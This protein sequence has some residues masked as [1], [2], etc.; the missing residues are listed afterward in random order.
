MDANINNLT[1]WGQRC[2]CGSVFN[3]LPQRLSGRES[4]R[5]NR[6]DIE[7]FVH[8]RSRTIGAI[9]LL[10]DTLEPQ[11][12]IGETEPDPNP[13]HERAVISAGVQ[14]EDSSPLN[15]GVDHGSRAHT[16]GGRSDGGISVELDVT[17]FSSGEETPVEPSVSEKAMSK[18]SST[19]ST[20]ISAIEYG[21]PDQI[22]IKLRKTVNSGPPRGYPLIRATRK[23]ETDRPRYLC[24]YCNRPYYCRSSLYQHVKV[25]HRMDGQRC[26]HC[27]VPFTYKVALDIHVSGH[28]QTGWCRIH[29]PLEAG[30]K[31]IIVTPTIID[32]TKE[33]DATLVFKAN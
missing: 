24:G 14:T 19:N 28:C 32:S 12:F 9:H 30:S 18:T 3:D 20:L 13:D 5:W 33:K 23:E 4:G 22:I 8:H 2:I 15:E 7:L 10:N 1:L 17:G 25:D 11:L 16:P 29:T 27:D 31:D 6:G 21:G 26:P